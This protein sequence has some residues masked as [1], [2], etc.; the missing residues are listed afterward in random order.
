MSVSWM[1][2]TLGVWSFGAM[3][4]IAVVLS[5]AHFVEETWPGSVI[6]RIAPDDAQQARSDRLTVRNLRRV[7]WRHGWFGWLAWLGMWCCRR[8][9]SLRRRP[10][11]RR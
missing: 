9:W 8:R 2:A 1:L 6:K 5:L 7:L 10:V 3:V 11:G 4:A